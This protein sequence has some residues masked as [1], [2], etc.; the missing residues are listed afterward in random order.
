MFHFL[1]SLDFFPFF[2]FLLMWH[3]GVWRVSPPGHAV[4][5]RFGCEQLLTE[6]WMQR[7]FQGLLV[8]WLFQGLSF[9]NLFRLLV[10]VISLQPNLTVILRW[11]IC[12][13]FRLSLACYVI[14]SVRLSRFFIFDIQEQVCYADYF[15]STL[16]NVRCIQCRRIHR[17]VRTFHIST[18]PEQ[19]RARNGG[20]RGGKTG[21]A[22]SECFPPRKLPYTKQFHQ[23]EIK[24]SNKT[25]ILLF[26]PDNYA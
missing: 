23:K 5:L 8:S 21:F 17:H 13:F 16:N 18:I 7:G 12:I 9:F 26:F 19:R 24:N 22:N 3:F 15:P 20:A 10:C 2:F 4:V 6:C 11:G 14:G 1:I 25:I